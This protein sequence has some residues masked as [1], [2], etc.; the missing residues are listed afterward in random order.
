MRCHPP[1]I[2]RC[3]HGGH[4]IE[5]VPGNDRGTGDRDSIFHVRGDPIVVGGTI[6]IDAGVHLA[7]QNAGN[8][9]V[10]EPRTAESAPRVVQLLDDPAPATAN[11][12]PV[13][14]LAYDRRFGFDDRQLSPFLLAVLPG[15][16]GLVAKRHR[17]AI[18]ET[19]P[20]ILPAALPGEDCRIAR[21][22]LVHHRR[23]R[24]ADPLA[25]A[26]AEILGDRPNLDPCVVQLTHHVEEQSHV[27]GHTA[28]HEHQDQIDRMIGRGSLL[29][30]PL[31]FGAL[32]GLTAEA[33]V[34][35]LLDDHN[36]MLGR[37]G[38][39]GTALGVD[40][41]RRTAL[42]VDRQAHIRESLG[43]AAAGFCQFSCPYLCSNSES[44]S[45]AS[46]SST[47][48]HSRRVTAGCSDE[49]G[50][51]RQHRSCASTFATFR[52]S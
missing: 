23:D 9:A 2:A 37:V 19:L 41:L 38:E 44:N 18:V 13:E 16:I 43:L 3:P 49:G 11:V 7:S 40:A 30:Q 46:A 47:S 32:V 51:S 20:C 29:H 17:P 50:T 35:K 6:V 31:K 45:R 15:D 22:L 1:G 25:T 28:E 34:G 33:G 36:V 5:L 12:S 24:P 52:C 27:S 8:V 42:L 10:G 39:N 4:A 26:L 14:D 21:L 48:M